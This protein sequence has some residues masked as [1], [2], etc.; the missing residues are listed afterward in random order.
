M[1]LLVP[2]LSSFLLYSYIA[3]YIIVT[4]HPSFFACNTCTYTSVFINNK[5]HKILFTIQY[6]QNYLELEGLALRLCLFVNLTFRAYLVL[7]CLLLVVLVFFIAG[8][9]E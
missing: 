8:S 6:Y 3:L 2:L 5:N 1:T 7:I 9:A 4:D